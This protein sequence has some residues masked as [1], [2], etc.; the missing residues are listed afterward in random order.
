M[1]TGKGLTTTVV[2]AVSLH[3]L[4][5]TAVSKNMFLPWQVSLQGKPLDS[6][7]L[8][9]SCLALS[10]NMSSFPKDLRQVVRHP[11]QTGPLFDAVTTGEVFTVTVV[12]AL[13]SQPE[14]FVTVEYKHLPS[15]Q[16]HLSKQL[17]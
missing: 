4:A 2:E 14:L 5:L 12:V 6:A 1:A 3:P 9:Y 16:S 10:I 11:A 8:N 7:N 15:Q 17:D 13:F